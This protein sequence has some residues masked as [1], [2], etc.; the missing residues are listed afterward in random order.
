MMSR[1]AGGPPSR[2]GTGA[3]EIVLMFEAGAS[4]SSPI[5]AATVPVEALT[6]DP[7][8]RASIERS[9]AAEVTPLAPTLLRVLMEWATPAADFF[10]GGSVASLWVWTWAVGADEVDRVLV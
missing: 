2:S 6:N 4:L 10:W 5:G 9:E 1:A 7:P 3:F 8:S